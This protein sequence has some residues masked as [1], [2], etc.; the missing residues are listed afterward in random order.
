MADKGAATN[1]W[2]ILI[3]INFYWKRENRLEGAVR[4]VEHIKKFLETESTPV[5]AHTFT[6]STPTDP[7]ARH[8]TEDPSLWPTFETVTNSFSTVASEA[9]PGDFVYIHYS[10]HGVKLPDSSADSN[11]HT[12]DFNVTC[13]NANDYMIVD[14]SSRE[15]PSVPTVQAGQE[16]ALNSVLAILEHLA[17]FKRIEAIGNG[18][19]TTSF[20]NSFRLHLRDH[21]GKELEARVSTD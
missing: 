13:N 19:S 10:G 16:G 12:Q 7:N 4:D 8:P 18:T 14:A 20:T 2:V 3:G 17:I 21:H 15:I 6:A 11:S 1:C 9:K 5:N